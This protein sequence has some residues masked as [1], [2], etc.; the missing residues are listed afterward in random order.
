LLK[1]VAG[2]LGTLQNTAIILS[3]FATLIAIVGCVITF[4][5]GESFET[6]RAGIVALIVFLINF[7][8]KSVW[9]KIVAGM[10]KV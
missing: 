3:V 4:L 5:T 8:R 10:E 1:G 2:L 7:P 6:L 9:E